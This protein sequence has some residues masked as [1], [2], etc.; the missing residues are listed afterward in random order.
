MGLNYAYPAY[1]VA[2]TPPMFQECL[3]AAERLLADVGFLVRHEKF[4]NAVAGMNGLILDG[5]RIRFHPSLIQANLEKILADRRRR[6][7]AE[8]ERETSDPD[9]KVSTGGFSMAVIDVQT[10]EVR[11]ATCQD[12]RDLI[13]L[14]DSYG[15]GGSYPVMPQDIPAMMQ[16]IACFKTCWESSDKVRP[17]DY[18]NIHQTDYIYEMHKVMGKTFTVTLTVTQPMALSEHD[19][20]IFLKFFPEWRRGAAINFQILDYQMLGVSKPVTTAGCLALYFA[21][22]LAVYTLFNLFD[23]GLEM[24]VHFGCGHPTDLRSV[25]W[26]FGHPRRHL[27]NY[28]NWRAPNDLC[29]VPVTEYRCQ[30]VLLETSSCALDEQAAMEKMAAALLGALQGARHFSYAGNLAVDDLFSGVQFVMDVEMVNYVKE[31][32]QAFQPPPELL[33]TDGLYD[34][35]RDVCLGRDEFIS[36]PDTVRAFRKLLPC[37]DLLYRE[38]LR[39]WLAHR[40]T[41]KDRARAECLR[42]LS[43]HRSAFQLPEDKQKALDEIYRSAE[44]HLLADATSRRVS[45]SGED[46][47]STRHLLDRDSN[48]A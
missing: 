21:E 47:A 9:W 10:D 39:Q 24:P 44:A 26:A 25:C 6:L 46:A 20:D 36:H 11:P 22:M 14:M 41:F 43:E 28:L 13:R 34:L 33:R 23:P 48:N 37:S 45:P 7:L 5:E 2:L 29:G 30:S 12:L 27:Y 38:K 18:Q 32:V 15:I 3:G 19:L 40:K 35:L 8:Q 17:Y 4:R 31:L 16:A 42:R 1:D